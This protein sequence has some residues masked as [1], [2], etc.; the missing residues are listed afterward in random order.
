MSQRE[1]V[2]TIKEK[3]FRTIGKDP[4]TMSS[5]DDTYGREMKIPFTTDR[6]ISFV[7][8]LMMVGITLE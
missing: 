8:N 3:T 4:R 2:P 6:S 5:P 7:G 1:V